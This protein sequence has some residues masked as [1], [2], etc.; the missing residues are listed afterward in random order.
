[1]LRKCL[2]AANVEMYVVAGAG[3]SRF[4]RITDGDTTEMRKKEAITQ[5][6]KAQTPYT[7][8]KSS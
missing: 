2:N 5:M 4:V 1:M 6:Q 7:I 3:E 8:A